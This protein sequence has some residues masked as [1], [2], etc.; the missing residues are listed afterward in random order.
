MLPKRR[1]LTA[2]FLVLL[3][4]LDAGKVYSEEVID[5]CLYHLRRMFEPSEAHK[6]FWELDGIAFSDTPKVAVPELKKLRAPKAR[7]L[8]H[9]P[10]N[11]EEFVTIFKRETSLKDTSDVSSAARRIASLGLSKDTSK[12]STVA[13]DGIIGDIGE[14]ILVFVGHNEKGEFRFLNGYSTGIS[15]L[16]NACRG[17][18]K[19]C[20]FLSCNSLAYAPDGSSVGVPSALSFAESLKILEAIDS[21]LRARRA[22]GGEKVSLEEMTRWLSDVTL[23]ADRRVKITSV[24]FKGCG[25]ASSLIVLSLLIE[26]LDEDKVPE[27]KKDNH[28]EIRD[29]L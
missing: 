15:E 14:D 5:V 23:E 12:W 19:V 3:I 22:T 17:A 8:L 26:A 1:A 21:Q 25:A 24:A 29:I 28:S 2:A 27:K 6:G 20:I 16:A 10:T 4:L 13:R 18:G 9:L 11:T 7:Y